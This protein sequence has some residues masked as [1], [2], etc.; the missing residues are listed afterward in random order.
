MSG[1]GA[2]RAGAAVAVATGFFITWSNLTVAIIG[3]EDH[4]LN[5]I[6]FA[7]LGI[8]LFGALIAH[9]DARRLVR[10]MQATAFAQALTAVVALV[11]DGACIF[12]ITAVFVA[13]WLFVAELFRRAA[14]A[15]QLPAAGA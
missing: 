8:A 14:A 2:D 12:V 5:Q 3:D 13:A 1:N 10:V 6:S 4:P 9:F 11:V 15:S 7:V